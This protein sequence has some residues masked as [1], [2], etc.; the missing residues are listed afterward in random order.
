[1]PARVALSR[2]NWLRA[3]N[4]YACFALAFNDHGVLVG[5]APYGMRLVGKE[6]ELDRVLRRLT[7]QGFKCRMLPAVKAVW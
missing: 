3:E 7:K 2:C 4:R 5:G 6:R 1:M